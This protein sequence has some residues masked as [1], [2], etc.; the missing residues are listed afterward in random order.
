MT[1]ELVNYEEKLA[2]MAK[3]ATEVERPSGSAIGTR[4]GILTYGGTPVPG[5]KLDVI[6]IGATHTNLYYEDKYDPDDIK[7]P[8]CFAYSK[9]GIDMAPHP[10]SSKPQHTDC[11]TCPMNQWKSDP[12]G[13]KGKACKN[14]RSLALIPADTKPEDVANAELA[15]LKLPVTSVHNWGQYVNKVAALYGRPPLGLITTVGMAPDL[16]TQFKVT[17][18]NGQLLGNDMLGP[19]FQREESVYPILERV[20]EPNS[21]T[22]E[23]TAPKKPKKY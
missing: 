8:V 3:Q 22:P 11:A 2:Q 16:K 23:E 20:Y 4:S 1:K 15:V 6:V 9:D 12:G 21:E 7:N 10:A 17:F 13:G 14:S 18:T 19:I 5:N